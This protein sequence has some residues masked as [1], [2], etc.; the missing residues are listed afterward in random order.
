M[1]SERNSGDR[2]TVTSY[3]DLKVWAAGIDLAER[4]YVA[5]E[6]YPKSEVFGLVSQMRRAAIS[7]PRIIHDELV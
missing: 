5:T 2:V 3:R 1:D 7:L 6:H 4:I